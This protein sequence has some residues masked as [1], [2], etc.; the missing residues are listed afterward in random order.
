MLLYNPTILLKANA[1]NLD[2]DPTK[3]TKTGKLTTETLF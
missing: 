1:T 3:T 2:G